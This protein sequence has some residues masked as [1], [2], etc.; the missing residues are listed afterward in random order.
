MNCTAVIDMSILINANWYV[1]QKYTYV[2]DIT[3]EALAS[4]V[5]SNINTICDKLSDLGYNINEIIMCCDY[6]ESWRKA[7]IPGYKA[8]RTDRPDF[9]ELKQ[10]VEA[11][12]ANKYEMLK[13]EGVEADDWAYIT[14]YAR[15]EDNIMLVSADEDYKQMVRR[16]NIAYYNTREKALYTF[17]D[18]DYELEVYKKLLN[19][20]PT[21][22]IPS[23]FKSRTYTSYKD[24]CYGALLA[25]INAAPFELTHIH[26]V[27]T[28]AKLTEKIDFT[29]L[30]DNMYAGC[31]AFDIYLK[32]MPDE[33]FDVVLSEIKR[34][35]KD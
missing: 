34:L 18:I 16:T 25:S 4:K 12:L 15:S 7:L 13:A 20:C 3:P 11:I 17:D 27:L 33:L 31:Y 32:A 9:R 14:T 35:K 23:L 29:N 1:M 22:E 10:G 30:A 6:G 24:A 28:E 21:D 26:S 19:G 8:S 5:D 2:D